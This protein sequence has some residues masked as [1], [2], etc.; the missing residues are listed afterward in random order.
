MKTLRWGNN[1]AATPMCSQPKLPTSPLL[2]LPSLLL[3]L[4][5]LLLWP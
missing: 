4:L 5:L 3:L 2:P 1:C